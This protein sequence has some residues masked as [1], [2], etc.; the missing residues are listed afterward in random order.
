MFNPKSGSSKAVRL[1]ARD[2]FQGSTFSN[3]DLGK[4]QFSDDYAATAD[5]KDSLKHSE[6]GEVSCIKISAVARNAEAAYGRIEMWLRATDNMPLRMEY[7]AKSGLLFKRMDLFT[8]KNFGS[9]RRPSVLKM[10]SFEKAGTIST[11]T[12]EAMNAA[13]VPVTVFNKNYL[14]R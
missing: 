8:I 11:I 7:Y 14:T 10:E 13:D 5:G 6:L 4:S 12:I 9:L 3:A 1:S 2:S